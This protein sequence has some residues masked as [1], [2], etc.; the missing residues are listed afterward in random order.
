MNCSVNFSQ[1]KQCSNLPNDLQQRQP[2]EPQLRE[3]KRRGARRK[4]QPLGQ[5]LRQK[6][7]IVPSDCPRHR[8]HLCQP[9]VLG[10]PRRIQQGRLRKAEHVGE[11]ARDSRRQ[12]HRHLPKNEEV[13]G[14]E[15]Q[16]EAERE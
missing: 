3:P 12:E 7:R 2:R 9:V 10:K 5:Q 15:G 8:R 1:N 13:E 16:E 14:G 11:A 4:S 6:H